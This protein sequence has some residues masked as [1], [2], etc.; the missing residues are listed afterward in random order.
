[1][2]LSA[3]YV[4]TCAC[5]FQVKI[6]F[7]NRRARERRGKDAGVMSAA[8]P[9]NM[10]ANGSGGGGADSVMAASGLDDHRHHHRQLNGLHQLRRSAGDDVDTA[11]AY[12][13]RSA[14]SLVYYTAANYK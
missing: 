7:Q 2:E 11:D 1:M 6:W 4:S 10:A 9:I 5:N 13:A 8:Q 14:S 12:S 3:L